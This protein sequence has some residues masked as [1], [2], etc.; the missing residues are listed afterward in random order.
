MLKQHRITTANNFKDFLQRAP[1]HTS[2]S[3]ARKRKIDVESL[4]GFDLNT[5]SGLGRNFDRKDIVHKIGART[6]ALGFDMASKGHSV[7][8]SLVG[9]QHGARG[10]RM[11]VK[12]ELVRKELLSRS[13]LM[14]L[15][16]PPIKRS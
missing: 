2:Q 14:K 15:Y 5:F 10:H 8:H 13:D 3:F 4:L 11:N 1:K 6:V 9:S 16:Q 12:A 7:N